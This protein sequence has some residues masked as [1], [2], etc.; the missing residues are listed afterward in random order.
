MRCPRSKITVNL[1]M[2]AARKARKHHGCGTCGYPK[3][4]QADQERIK[5]LVV[6]RKLEPK[7]S[8]KFTPLYIQGLSPATIK[9]S[10]MVAQDLFDKLAHLLG[11]R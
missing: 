2:C 11:K 4:Y 10:R 1:E 3:Q 8:E 7:P 5:T 9:M 6:G